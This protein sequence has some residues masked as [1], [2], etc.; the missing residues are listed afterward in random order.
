MQEVR[1]FGR[2]F[3]RL[4]SEPSDGTAEPPARDEGSH[5]QRRRL[6]HDKAEAIARYNEG[7]RL[8]LHRQELQ[9]RGATQ[10]ASHG[11]E[12]PTFTRRQWNVLQKWDSGE[13]R[14][15]LNQAVV[16]LGHGRLR[17]AQGDYLDIGGSTGGGS[18]RIIDSWQ[19]PDWSDFLPDEQES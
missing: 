8:A 4:H 7:A 6:H 9:R 3:G 14:A 11:Q 13:L 19:P 15:S 1:D 18:R 17:S 10:P 5:E 2:D 12:E 16:A